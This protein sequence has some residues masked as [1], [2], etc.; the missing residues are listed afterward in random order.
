[1]NLLEQ[2]G[3]VTVDTA[4]RLHYASTR[5]RLPDAVHDA[6]EVAEARQRVDK[7]RIEMMRGYAE[8]T[9]CRRQFLLGYFGEAYPNP[10]GNCDVCR[11]GP[12]KAPAPAK[13]RRTRSAAKPAPASPY[14]VNTTVKH[15]EWGEGVVM[16]V[17]ADRITV[18]FDSVGYRTLA[19]KVLK[20]DEGLLVTR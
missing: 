7:S 3:A 1:V 16:R 11:S 15:R 20:Q 12:A 9:G 5:R 19:L 8:T 6:V 4:G 17:E 10:C 18:L 14:P 2:A 13:G